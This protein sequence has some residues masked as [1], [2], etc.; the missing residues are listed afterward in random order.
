MINA[1]W[2]VQVVKHMSVFLLKAEGTDYHVSKSFEKMLANKVFYK[3]FKELVLF[4]IS[5]Y[6]HGSLVHTRTGFIPL[7]EIYI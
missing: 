7:S 4:G 1:F 3:I 2:L 6:E 5:R